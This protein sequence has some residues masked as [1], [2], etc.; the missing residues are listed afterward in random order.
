MKRFVD[1]WGNQ[2]VWND[3]TNNTEMGECAFNYN[4]RSIIMNKAHP[5]DNSFECG[6]KILG[7]DSVDDGI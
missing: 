5:F 2:T 3:D 7:E 4:S 6:T 1:E